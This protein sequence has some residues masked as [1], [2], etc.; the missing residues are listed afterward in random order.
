MQAR[1]TT[2][3]A[4]LLALSASAMAVVGGAPAADP[5]GAARHLVLIVAGRGNFCT[6]TAIAR[7]LV[8]QP[9]FRDVAL[10]VTHPQFD[11]KAMLAHRVSADVAL[12]KLAAPLPPA[13]A[14]APLLGERKPIV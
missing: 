5:E 6:G 13:Y 7:E 2:A 8:R 12:L 3:L 11:I 10:V 14:P 4:C 1:L 9:T